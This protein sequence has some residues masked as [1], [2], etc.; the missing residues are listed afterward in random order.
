MTAMSMMDRDRYREEL[1]QRERREKLMR[2]LHRAVPE[3]ARRGRH[4]KRRP[5]W[6]A[7]AVTVILLAGCAILPVAVTSR[8]DLQIS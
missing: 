5:R 6:V 1:A 2:R 3:L 7:V 4:A 8:C